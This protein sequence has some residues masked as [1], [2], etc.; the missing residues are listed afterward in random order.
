MPSNYKS[1]KL[2]TVGN[3]FVVDEPIYPEKPVRPNKPL[4]VVIG[5][6][7]GLVLGFLTCQFAAAY[8][9]GVIRDPKK[10]ELI[11]GQSILAILPIAT[12]QIEHIER[13]EDKGVFMLSQEKPN[14]TR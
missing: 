4:M 6:L 3:V 11:S 10:L 9:T 14:S 13:T 1:L 7:I 12:D 8:L 5:A 2:D